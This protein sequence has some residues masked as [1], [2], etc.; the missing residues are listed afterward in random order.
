MQTRRS[1]A[2]RALAVL[3]AL[4]S[5]AGEAPRSRHSFDKELAETRLALEAA[6][7]NL[8]ALERFEKSGV[9]S[10]EPTYNEETRIHDDYTTTYEVCLAVLFVGVLA[11]GPALILVA[12]PGKV[13]KT[14]VAQCVLVILLLII[15]VYA[16][17]NVVVFKSSHFEGRRSLTIPES[18]YLLAQIVTTVGYGDILPATPLGQIL[19]GSFVILCLLFIMEMVAVVTWMMIERVQKYSKEVAQNT[20][21]SICDERAGDECLFYKPPEASYLPVIASGGCVLFFFVCG[22]LF[23]H[24]YP[25]EEKSW[26][27]A[28][29]FSLITFST[30]GFGAFTAVTVGGQVFA[31][32]WMVFGVASFASFIGA[33]AELVMRLKAKERHCEARVRKE[34]EANFEALQIETGRSTVDHADFL[35]LAALQL[36]IASQEHIEG[37]NAF[38]KSLDVDG[39]GDVGSDELA[40]WTV[41]DTSMSVTF[42]LTDSEDPWL[43][44]E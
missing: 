1:R 35:C 12:Q 29:Y 13:T 23:F 30:V 18:V 37:I 15:A 31:A 36:G 3:G 8:A 7:A 33:F 38:F 21:H 10:P 5:A 28:M 11:G 44:R 42:G 43:N 16:F 14:C 2:P 27:Q 20:F 6:Q 34:M 25:G 22:V 40:R 32:F 19:I 17:T 41:N 39:S 24:L 9:S 26:F 4:C